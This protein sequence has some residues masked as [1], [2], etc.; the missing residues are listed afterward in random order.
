MHYNMDSWTHRSSLNTHI[1]RTQNVNAHGPFVCRVRWAHEGSPR[2]S[3]VFKRP[4][5]EPWGFQKSTALKGRKK[6][7]STSKEKSPKRWLSPEG[8]SSSLTVQ[9]APESVKTAA[10]SAGSCT[11]DFNCHQP[12]WCTCC[13][14]CCSLLNF[15][16]RVK[17]MRVYPNNDPKCPS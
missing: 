6:K 12:P 5:Q 17:R 11:P 13:C 2:V 10:F 3:T 4:P 14:C 8:S 1:K 9:S 15:S 7:Y 16:S